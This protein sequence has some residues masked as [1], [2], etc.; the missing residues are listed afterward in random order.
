[1]RASRL[2]HRPGKRVLRTRYAGRLPRPCIGDT[3]ERRQRERAS[4]DRQ[5]TGW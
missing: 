4:K 1:L 3:L 2:H 5:L